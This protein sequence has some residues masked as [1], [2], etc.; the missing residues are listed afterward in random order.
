MKARSWRAFAWG[1]LTVGLAGSVAAPVG[2]ATK[3]QLQAETLSLSNMPTGWSVEKLATGTATDRTGCLKGLRALGLPAKGIARAD[4]TYQSHTVPAFEE[5][6]ESGK[7]A[8][9]RYEHYLSI[10][11]TC[12]QVSVTTSK[13][14][15]VSGSVKA[16][17]FPTVGSSSSAFALDWSAGGVNVGTDIVLF[18]VG[19][20]DGRIAYG[21]YSPDKATL[22]ALATAAVD[23][24][25]GKP[26]PAI[27][28]N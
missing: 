3:S 5:T 12:K 21:D 11:E 4:V 23:K 1:A 9:P 6:L 15:Q 14:I 26:V 28:S 8:L 7:G 22:Q 27:P 24:V 25:E 20:V 16:M 13:G 17:S 18:R 19:Q 10:L 2:A